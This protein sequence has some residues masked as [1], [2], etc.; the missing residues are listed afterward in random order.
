MNTFESIR[1]VFEFLYI[2][3]PQQ[4]DLRLSSPQT[5]QGAGGE[6]RT[7]DRKVP[8]DLKAYSLATV[9]PTPRVLKIRTSFIAI[10]M[11]FPSPSLWL[12][13]KPLLSVERAGVGASED[14]V[15]VLRSTGTFLSW[16]RALPLSVRWTDEESESLR[17]SRCRQIPNQPYCKENDFLSD[18]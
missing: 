5:G 15:L 6:A 17:S 3:S 9:P 1:L 14:S 10:C 7:H 13:N 11:F 8:T 16:V 12:Q 4:D 2:A 18:L